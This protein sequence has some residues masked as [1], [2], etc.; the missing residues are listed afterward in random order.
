MVRGFI[1]DSFINKEG[2]LYRIGIYAYL[3]LGKIAELSLSAVNSEELMN[4]AYSGTMIS[5]NDLKNYTNRDLTSRR[6][7]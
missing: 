7:M 3:I 5:V 2:L 4:N 1:S 6:T